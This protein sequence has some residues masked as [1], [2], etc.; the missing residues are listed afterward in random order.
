MRDSTGKQID[1]VYR[2]E[3]V[4][5]SATIVFESRGGARGSGDE[6]NTEY[7]KGLEELLRVLKESR[8]QL[9]DVL[10]DSERVAHRP[11][12]DRRVQI[13][14]ESY[15]LTIGDPSALRKRISAGAA[16]V[17]RTK[18]AKGGGNPNKRL[19]LFTSEP[20]VA[21]LAARLGMIP[22]SSQA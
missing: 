21:A 17:G 8:V 3:T 7:A 2:L 12:S 11:V 13:V 16:K 4:G 9:V 22:T 15:P 18:G 14:G 1:A 19:R 6:Q 20:S 5:D 10:V